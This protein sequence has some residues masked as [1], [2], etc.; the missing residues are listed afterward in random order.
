MSV[1][2]TATITDTSESIEGVIDDPDLIS[3]EEGNEEEKS[4]SSSSAGTGP[5]IISTVNM[6][7]FLSTVRTDNLIEI[8]GIEYEKED[9]TI[10]HFGTAQ[11]YG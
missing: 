1:P 7:R 8:T 9:R 6:S 11:S 3:E 4:E 10:S 2:D 5:A